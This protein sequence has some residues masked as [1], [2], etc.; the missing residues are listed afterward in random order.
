MTGGALSWARPLVKVSAARSRVGT[1]LPRLQTETT[2]T[3]AG[4]LSWAQPLVTGI[5]DRG[6]VTSTIDLDGQRRGA[7]ADR[8]L[9]PRPP[10]L[11]PQITRGGGR[12]RLLGLVSPVCGEGAGESGVTM[13]IIEPRWCRSRPCTRQGTERDPAGRRSD[14]RAPPLHVP[15]KGEGGE[16]WRAHERSWPPGPS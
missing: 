12:C 11:P 3:K 14:E 5:V 7:R 10:R 8:V 6:N 4:A 2:T 9:H 13:E 16:R 15:K 1:L